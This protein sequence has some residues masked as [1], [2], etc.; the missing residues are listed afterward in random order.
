MPEGAGLRKD[1]FVS[2]VRWEFR[3]LLEKRACSIMQPDVSHSV[4]RFHNDGA[5]ADL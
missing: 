5:V 3:K 1:P 4:E 2:W